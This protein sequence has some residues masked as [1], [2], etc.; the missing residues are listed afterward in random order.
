MIKKLVKLAR[1]LPIVVAAVAQQ[2]YATPPAREEAAPETVAARW[3]NYE[4][5][6]ASRACWFDGI[7]DEAASE[8]VCGVVKVPEDRTD[9]R[10]ALIDIAVMTIGV[11][12]HRSSSG[13]LVWLDNGPGAASISKARSLTAIDGRLAKLRRATGLVFFDQRGTGYSERDFCRNVPDAFTYGVPVEPEGEAIFFRNMRGC[14][15]EARARGIPVSAYSSWHIALDVRDIRKALGY[16]KWNVLGYLTSN[17]IA[18]AVLQVDPQGVRSAIMDS[19]VPLE[20]GISDAASLAMDR[21]LRALSELCAAANGC[22]A[23]NGDFHA[24]VLAI[25]DQYERAP[26]VIEGLNPKA[27]TG[28][29]LVFDDRIAANF[30]MFMIYYSSAHGDLPAILDALEDRDR[31]AIRVY[32]ENWFQPPDGRDSQATRFAIKCRNESGGLGTPAATLATARK[33]AS[34][35][36]RR[37]G[38]FRYADDCA[39]LDFGGPDPSMKRTRFDGP[40]LITD[41]ALNPAQRPYISRAAA[42]Q[43]PAAQYI[44]FRHG[45]VIPLL[46]E[47]DGCGGQLLAEFLANPNDPVRSECAANN[48]APDFLMGYRRN[49]K[50]GQLLMNLQTGNYPM[51]PIALLLGVVVTLVAIPGRW[52]IRWRRSMR[53]TGPVVPRAELIG[54]ISILFS[55]VAIAMFALSVMRWVEQ[56][57]A[58]VPA[59]V[60]SSIL[61]SLAVAVVAGLLAIVSLALA[62]RS[63]N[64]LSKTSVVTISCSILL[65][66]AALGWISSIV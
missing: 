10:S 21:A 18:Q 39:A 5:T 63:R 52:A 11:D 61:G 57:P 7:E 13:P 8:V 22:T 58:A 6:F 51:L 24:R 9:A 26:L 50:P 36:E 15:D 17:G 41:G 42:A 64:Q 1:W 53:E 37:L 30:L 40:V 34:G 19:P 38:L 20:Y 27:A 60:P 55:V 23:Q 46:S 33:Q 62:W 59:G 45:G 35:I 54:W 25:L 43:F 47:F 16:E 3:Q 48:P 44:L 12:R 66:F 2:S 4:P 49:S 28:G 31:V 29:R 32:A 56:H 65:T 14:L